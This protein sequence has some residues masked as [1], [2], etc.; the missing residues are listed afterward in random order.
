MSGIDRHVLKTRIIFS[1]VL[2]IMVNA[3]AHAQTLEQTLARCEGNDADAAIIACTAAIQSGRLPLPALAAVYSNRGGARMKKQSYDLAIAD[4]DQA[5]MIDPAN[6]TNV[7]NRG[8]AFETTGKLD[9]A[10]RDYSRAIELSVNDRG[11]GYTFQ[12][13]F[14]P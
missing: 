13:C 2:F 8:F 6:A 1:A 4:F 7:H 14:T 5:I 9:D 10:L 11:F 12:Y 3:A